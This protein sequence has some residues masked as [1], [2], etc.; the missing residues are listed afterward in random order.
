LAATSEVV[1]NPLK[2]RLIEESK[3]DKLLQ[4]MLEDAEQGQDSGSK[5]TLVADEDGIAYL[6]SLIY[7]PRAMR[8]EIIKMHHDL[9]TSGHQGI[10]KT[11][12]KNMWSKGFSENTWEPVKNLTN[13]R[14][15]VQ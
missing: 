10:E 7:V 14:Q 1:N 13:C 4:G 11:S 6:H 9:P 8:K 2:E 3:K 5:S 12:T 15:L